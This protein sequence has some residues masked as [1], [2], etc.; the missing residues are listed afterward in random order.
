MEKGKLYKA[1]YIYMKKK[2]MLSVPKR[3]IK[4]G[5]IKPEFKGKCA[6]LT[7]AELEAM[8]EDL[9]EEYADQEIQEISKDHYDLTSYPTPGVKYFFAYQNINFGIE[10]I[11]YWIVHRMHKNEDFSHFDKII[12]T[13]TAAASSSHFGMMQARL[14]AQQNQ[15]SQYLKG[16]SDMVKGLFQI[17][18][19]LRILDE[20]LQ[21]YEDTY[22]EKSPNRVSS[23][24]V[25]KGLW[26]DLVEGGPKNPASVY[27]MAAEVGFT[28][29]PDVFFRVQV[30]DPKEI[31]GVV[32]ATSFNK[33][34]KEV[35]KRKLRQYYE[36]KKRTYVEL[37]TRKKFE[38]KYLRQHYDTI[39]LY[40][41]WIKPYLRNIA[42]LQPQ[43]KW[44]DT[45]RL[46][47]SFEGAIVEI[48]YLA[49]KKT[50]G[51]TYSSVVVTNFIYSVRPQLEYHLQEYQHKGPV[52][53]GR[54]EL[55]LRAY[56]WTDEQI[57]NY[58]K[59]K[60]EEN[61]YILGSIDASI[62]EALDSL[63]DELKAYLELGGETFEEKKKKEESKLE[64]NKKM[65]ATSLD[66]FVSVF[67]GFGELFGAF[68]LFNKI[69]FKRTKKGDPYLLKKDKNAAMDGAKSGAFMA[70]HYY[71]K[72][73]GITAW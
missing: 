27:G 56:S 40:V 22:D 46:I 44:Y 72:S 49:R 15:A 31:D 39:K 18:R 37:K 26:I 9:A 13:Y 12:D 29:L 69:S 30:K 10:Y 21:Y 19:E 20:R 45:A 41:N 54:V 68:G 67:K 14:S 60:E 25:L 11:Y 33:K 23:E 34:I 17:V 2:K 66:P 48:E 16:I 7:D 4:Y 61:L 47:N 42:M 6:K 63:G 64:K 52:H 57:E 36:W 38:I 3:L 43:D 59:Y 8:P 24:I 53:V 55:N 28:I 70:Y 1:T 65:I 32:D 62:K 73:H 50:A 5:F 71:K 51:K 58:K 35:L